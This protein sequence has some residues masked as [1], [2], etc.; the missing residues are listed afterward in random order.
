MI[1][2][3]GCLIDAFK[4]G[5][6]SCIL[7]QVNCQGKMASGVA[8]VIRNEFPKHYL[9]YQNLFETY[10]FIDDKQYL[11]GRNIVTETNHG[12][13]V[14]LFSQLYYGYDGKRYTN[15]SAIVLA[16]HDLLAYGYDNCN[17]IGL[18]KYL[19]CG[20]GGGDWQIVES[21]LED[22]EELYNVEFHTYEI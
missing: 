1:E 20:L 17:K 11:L 8:K 22:L 21:L 6:V 14:G 7:H 18:P 10:K 13:I 12:I 5:E 15:Y 3:K 19:G 2:H 9:D 16:I 4:S